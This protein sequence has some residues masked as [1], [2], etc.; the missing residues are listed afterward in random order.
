MGTVE[1]L[2]LESMHI[3]FGILSLGGTEPTIYLGVIYPPLPIATG[4]HTKRPQ[5]KTAITK[6]TTNKN[7]HSLKQPQSD[8]KRPHSPSKWKVIWS[9][10][11]YNYRLVDWLEQYMVDSRL[12]LRC[13][14]NDVTDL[15][16]L[17]K[18][19]WNCR[20]SS[21]SYHR[22]AILW[23]KKCRHPQKRKY[24]TY[25]NAARGGPSQGYS[26][27]SQKI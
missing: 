9:S 27:Q 24:I 4:V 8:T 5:T 13:V 25:C 3:A 20:C 19:N 1:K 15:H 14:T 6:T 18:F 11:F 2:T 12:R 22:P 10:N 17:A 23:V 7:G 26:Q 16:S 21:F